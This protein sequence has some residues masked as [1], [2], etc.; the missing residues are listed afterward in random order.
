MKLISENTKDAIKNL[1]SKKNNKIKKNKSDKAII[2]ANKN[3]NETKQNAIM[4]NIV[5][6]CTCINIIYKNNC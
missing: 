4:C 5:Y 1:I 6:I 3:A 2:K